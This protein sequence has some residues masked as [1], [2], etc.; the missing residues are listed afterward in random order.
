MRMSRP[1]I[2][3]LKEIEGESPEVYLDSGG[4]PTIGVG[5]LLTKSERT[6]GKIKIGN[7]IGDYREGLSF[8]QIDQL[9]SQDLKETESIIRTYVRYPLNQNQY[10]ALVSFVFNI[11]ISAFIDSTLLRVLNEGRPE[12]VPDQMRRWIYDNGVI[13]VG[14]KNRRE[15]E[16][17]LWESSETFRV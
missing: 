2:D 8:P 15:K 13:V 1:G 3:L 4:A 14:L 9:L 6:S 17:E 7:S 16:I 10:D 5:H 12:L 11:G